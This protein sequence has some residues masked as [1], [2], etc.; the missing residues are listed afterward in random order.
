MPSSRATFD[1]R[2]FSAGR[3]SG[4][5]AQPAGSAMQPQPPAQLA[6]FRSICEETCAPLQADLMSLRKQVVQLQLQIAQGFQQQHR[7]NAALVCC[8]ASF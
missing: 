6:A 1:G 2:P 5:A 7:D 4:N 8:T 3:N